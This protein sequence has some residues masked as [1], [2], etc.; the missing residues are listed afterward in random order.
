MFEGQLKQSTQVTVTVL[1]ISSTDHIAGKTGLSAGLTI[2][3]SKAG[4]TPASISPTVSELDSTNMPG[5]YSLVL[6][7]THTNTLGEL[8][9]RVSGSGADPTDVKWQVMARLNDD[10]A[11]PATSGRSMVVDAAGLVDANAVKVGPSGS[12]TA[13]T[14]RDIGASVLLSAGTGTG[15]LDFTSGIVK[16]N[17]AQI[18]GTALT[19]TAGQIAAGFKKFFNIA[20]P[21]ATMDHLVLVDT[22]TTYTGNTPQTGDSYA[23]L[24]AP[25]LASF[26]ADN[27]AIKADTAAIKAKTDN[28]PSDP[29][30]ES[31]V[32]AATDAIAALI[33]TPAVSVSDDLAAVKVDTAA[34][35][36]KTDNL[37]ANPADVSDVPTATENADALLNR[38]MSA[39]SDTND[40]SP[41][42]ALRAIRNK[43]SISGTTQTVTKED[44]TTTAWTTTLSTTAGADPVTGSDPA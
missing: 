23:R 26:S 31:L 34:V 19:E 30:D 44:D 38:D 33:G 24:G 25:T 7:T 20:T 16:A 12:G 18:L 17:L 10:L 27:A 6:T 39:V 11:Y 43:W 35:K 4:G 9:I 21:A 14:A 40:R 2:Y 15:Q 42:N 28:L 13:L 22:V 5:L 8:A 32:I 1:M 36:A 3:A 41:L 37:P 29:A